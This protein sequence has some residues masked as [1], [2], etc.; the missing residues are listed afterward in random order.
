MVAKL[1]RSGSLILF[2]LFLSAGLVSGLNGPTPATP[3]ANA[4]SSASAPAPASPGTGWSSAAL[5][6]GWSSTYPVP[7]PQPKTPAVVW[8]RWCP[9]GAH[10]CTMFPLV[11]GSSGAFEHHT[12]YT[13]ATSVSGYLAN[14]TSNVWRADNGHGYCLSDFMLGCNEMSK[15]NEFYFVEVITSKYTDP[16][17]ALSAINGG[18]YHPKFIRA[19]GHLVCTFDKG[20]YGGP[21]MTVYYDRQVYYMET[22]DANGHPGQF[23]KKFLHITFH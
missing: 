21:G 4:H 2:G 16:W 18:V 17:K 20:I 10:F 23:A 15:H 7:L 14:W 12:D 11:S 9:K 5:R 3:S 22:G 19:N 13:S 8:Q 1:F 6:P